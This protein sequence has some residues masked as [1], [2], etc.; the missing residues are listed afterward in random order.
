MHPFDSIAETFS[1]TPVRPRPVLAPRVPAITALATAR[2]SRK[3]CKKLKWRARDVEASQEYNLQLDVIN[4]RQEIQR[5][6]EYRQILQMRTFN[7]RDDLDGYYV[8]AIMEYHRVFG[9]GYQP[10]AAIDATQFIFQVMDEN[11][12]MGRFSGREVLLHQWERYTKA[13]SGLEFRYLHSR[14]VSGQGRTIVTSYSTYKHLVTQDTLDIMFPDAMRQHPRIA[15]RMLGRVFHG[16]SQITFTFDTQ[17]H[18][19]ISCSFQLDVLDVFANLLREPKDLCAIFQGARISEEF[20]IGDVTFY[21]ERSPQIEENVGHSTTKLEEKVE[22][23]FDLD[24][25]KTWQQE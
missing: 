7:R 24:S 13:L 23:R 10:G 22:P 12:V 20:F 16:F 18:Y 11:V 21:P 15:A 5:L 4:L 2:R 17:T 1:V 3:N 8:K 25:E 19:I 6:I 14:V 9:S